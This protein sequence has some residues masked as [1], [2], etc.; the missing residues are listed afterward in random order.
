L[1]LGGLS[2][3][4]R[5]KQPGLK[6]SVLVLSLMVIVLSASFV[7]VAYLFLLGKTDPPKPLPEGFFL[8][9]TA[10]GNVT[11]TKALIDKVKGYTN[12]ITF[13]NLEVTENLSRLVEVSDYAYDAGLSFLVFTVYP[14]PFA[15]NF[16][17][18]PITW[19][20]EAKSR[21]GDKFMG[22]YLWDEPGGNQ[23]DRGSFRQFDNNTKPYDYR[24]AAN[25]FTYYLYL[26]IRDFIKTDKLFTADYGLYWYDF[27]AGYDAVLCNF[28][29]NNSRALAIAQC[30][31]AAEMHNKTWGTIVTWTY[32]NPPYIA[33]ASEVYQDMVTGYDAGA[34]YVVVFNYPQTGPYGLLTEAHFDAIKEFRNY[35]L[36]H[37]QK[38]SSN[39][40][41]V[42]YIIPDNYGWGLR[43]PDDTIWGVW[44]ADNKSQQ[45]WNGVMSMVETYGSNFDIIV[46]SPW[47]R[48]FGRYHY[49][50]LIW[51]NA[52]TI[53]P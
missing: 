12:F 32:E 22:Y 47:T 18:N 44:D 48:L 13:T 11:E 15:K 29:W 9:V 28:G 37:P 24:D 41:R 16:T 43:R 50:K 21:Y 8:G 10:S 27:E 33:S 7:S 52:T 19:V 35:V 45:I 4:A 14:S 23:L 51:W 39:V 5:V 1:V 42:A 25:T 46:G 31:G 53:T 6:H 49:D 26:Q 36:A 2:S 38:P 30:R 40:E 17:F 3:M 20:T 34:K